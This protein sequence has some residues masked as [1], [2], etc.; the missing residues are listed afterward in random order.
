[1][2]SICV[3]Q[4]GRAPSRTFTRIGIVMLACVASPPASGQRADDRRDAIVE[5]KRI[6]AEK[7]PAPHQLAA[8]D[9]PAKRQAAAAIALLRA[10]QT[11]KVWV[12]LKQP[13]G[14]SFCSP[15]GDTVAGSFSRRRRG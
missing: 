4:A 2:A 5:W 7:E 11:E 10:R 8:R 15:D 3:E 13:I 9:A 12:L 6:L 14:N 1:M